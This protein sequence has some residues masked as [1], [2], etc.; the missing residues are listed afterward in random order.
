MVAGAVL[1]IAAG[2]GIA[3]MP[4]PILA[5]V[6]DPPPEAVVPAANLALSSLTALCYGA[7]A[8]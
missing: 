8:V 5:G 4:A 2:A 6:F 1:G 3:K 7:L